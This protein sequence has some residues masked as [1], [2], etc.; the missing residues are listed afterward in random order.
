MDAKEVIE[1]LYFCEA[2]C[3]YCHSGCQTEKDRDQLKKCMMMDED[4]AG[5]CRLTAISLERGS[6][7]AHMFMKLCAQ[8][9]E[10]CAEECN[11]HSHHEHCKECAEACLKCAEACLS[12][13]P[14]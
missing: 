8:I 10:M 13:Q 2:A 12:F 11:R 4:C 6:E 5:I 14:V 7:N 3:N 1:Q 9:C